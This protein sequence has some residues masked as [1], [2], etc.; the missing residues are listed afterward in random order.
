MPFFFD[1]GL[2]SSESKLIS[3]SIFTIIPF[4]LRFFTFSSRKTAPPPTAIT[5]PVT[6]DKSSIAALSLSRNALSPSSR[7]IS[8]ALFAYFFAISSS[9]SKKGLFRVDAKSLATLLLPHEGIPHRT[10]FVFSFKIEVSISSVLSS[11]SPPR[12]IL[13]ASTACFT[14][15]G[16]P[17]E[18][19]TPKLCACI[20]NSVLSGLYTK[21]NAASKQAN[22]DKSIGLTLTLGNVPT[23]V[24]LK[25]T[26][27]RAAFS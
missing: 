15:I 13:S 7:I 27:A 22:F 17:S 25:T 24:A 1:S 19:I 5:A 2:P 23:G 12:H 26:S 10:I 20:T 14:S 21:S 6:S 11:N 4:L 16:K 3:L 18:T 8:S 9:V